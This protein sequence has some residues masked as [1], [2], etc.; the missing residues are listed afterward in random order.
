[1]DQGQLGIRRH[2]VLDGA[3]WVTSPVLVASNSWSTS[4]RRTEHSLLNRVP[5][6]TFASTK[7]SVSPSTNP[8]PTRVSRVH[9]TR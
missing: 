3:E 6:R 9:V 8:P 2:I 5:R 4:I 1:M 7:M